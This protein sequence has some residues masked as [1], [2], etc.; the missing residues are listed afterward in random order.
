MTDEEID[1]FILK[2][3]ERILAAIL[4]PP[5]PTG[6]SGTKRDTSDTV[7]DKILASDNGLKSEVKAKSLR[8]GIDSGATNCSTPG[9]LSTAKILIDLVF[10][11][12]TFRCQRLTSQETI[13]LRK[14]KK[15][16][17]VSRPVEH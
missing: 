4:R 12:N 16:E 14:V 9:L 17:I 8:K 13:E 7:C 15:I 5:R 1:S 11:L 10:C 6:I 3:K 2:R